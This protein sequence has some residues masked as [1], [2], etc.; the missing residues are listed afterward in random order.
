MKTISSLLIAVLMFTGAVSGEAKTTKGPVVQIAL[1]LDTSSSMDGLLEQ[2]RTQLWS[3]VNQ[4]ATAKRNGRTPTLEV[5]LYEYGNSGLPA[6]AGFLRQ[7]LPLTTDLDKVSEELFKLKTNGGDEYCGKT[8]QSAVDGLQWS[9]SEKDLKLIFIAGNEAFS[10]GP[11]RYQDAVKNAVAKGITVNTIF[12]GSEPEG[13]RTGWKDGAVLADGR[14]MVIDQNRPVVHIEAPQDAELA[15]LNLQLNDTFVFYGSRAAEARSRQEAQDG[16]VGK[17]SG[18][19]AA[20]R[21]AVKASPQYMISAASFD[22]VAATGGGANMG[23]VKEEEMPEAMKGMSEDERKA[24]VAA[25]SKERAEIQA[26][27]GK[28]SQER[29]KFVAEKRKSMAGQEASLDAVIL[30]AVKEQAAKKSFKF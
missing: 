11:S 25:K 16:L 28:L 2:A 14:F 22:M 23:E 4:F 6:G 9:A 8:I 12:C 7:V 21:T 15:R 20:L 13:L 19:V 29:E 26:K 17:V 18:A 1:L 30:Q 24:Y 3:V 5:A 10:Q 27:I